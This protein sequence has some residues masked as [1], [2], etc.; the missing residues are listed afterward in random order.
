MPKRAGCTK[1]KKRKICAAKK[2]KKRTKGKIM[3]DTGRA[4]NYFFQRNYEFETHDKDKKKISDETVE[5]W[6]ERIERE[7]RS[8]QAKELAFIFHDKD[9][10]SE[11]HL[12]G[13]HCHAY[14]KYTHPQNVSRIMKEVKAESRNFDV[15]KNTANVLL[16]LT[17][18][19]VEAIKAKKVRYEVSE[20]K[21][22]IDDVEVT[23][24]E[25]EIWY[26]NNISKVGAKTKA[27]YQLEDV[28]AEALI[29]LKNGEL[30]LHMVN[31]FLEQ[32]LD[33][34]AA[35][36][37]WAK[38]KRLF[39]QAQDEYFQSLYDEWRENGRHF[40]LI[41]IN[42][43]SSIGKTY[44]AKKLAQELNVLRGRKKGAVHFAPSASPSGNLDFVDGY[45][46]ELSTIFDDL[47]SVTFSFEQFLSIFEK[48]RVAKVSS[49]FKN[50]IWLSELV[51]IS[52]S[53]NIDDWTKSLCS[54]EL[55][56]Y[57]KEVD[58]NNVLYQVR[59]RF[60]LIIDI[61]DKDVVLSKY[62]KLDNKNK[63]TLKV[64]DTLSFAKF[65]DKFQS[66]GFQE[67]LIERIFLELD[68]IKHEPTQEE[69]E[70]AMAVVDDEE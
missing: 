22:F 54:K 38:S 8:V 26:R 62:V 29:N 23:G 4:R 55:K 15:A 61:T 14:L 60:E 47:S 37:L 32:R 28:T 57:S 11:G 41:Y 51:V 6:K 69:L 50:K 18:T 52:K 58:K 70:K 66:E 13:I 2:A 9:V 17:H 43:K 1:K 44:F 31:E 24:E 49:R 10:D 34:T 3:A 19:S 64:I 25:K 67:R 56:N 42:G 39:E 68:Y 46:L 35:T 30:A 48:D 12:K 53:Q 40:N 7:L 65:K 45:E 63:H 27:K 16:Y 20:I 36:L 33:L 21:L 59:R 5:E